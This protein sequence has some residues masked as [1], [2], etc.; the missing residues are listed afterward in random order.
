MSALPRA[1]SRSGFTLIELLVVIAI[2][3]VL[4]ALLLPA[5]QA[6]REAARRSQCVNN[7]KQIG[8]GLHNYESANGTF[9]I[10]NETY[11]VGATLDTGCGPIRRHGFFTLILGQ[12]EQQSV[13]NSVNFMFAAGANPPAMIPGVIQSTALLTRISSY[14]CPSD[15]PGSPYT[16]SDVPAIYNPWG[17][18]SYAGSAGGRNSFNYVSDKACNTTSD[19][20]FGGNAAY[21]VADILDGTSNTIFA[22]ESSKFKNDPPADHAFNTWTQ[23]GNYTSRAYPTVGRP[24]VLLFVAPKMN[25]SIA[26]ML[27]PRTS[28]DDM[29][30]AILT[31]TGDPKWLAV[32][33]WGFRSQHPGGANFLFG[34]GSVKFL[35][36][37]INLTTYLSLGTRANGE[38]ISADQY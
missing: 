1:R 21:R 6:A 14:I 20:A 26:P 28:V 25:G 19:G 23:A 17:Q 33:Q 36:E 11:E 22:G 30:N 32:G 34:D 10:G 27:P 15:F 9:P 24:Q 18:A 4:I 12:I 13:Y 8:L 35:K 2:I 16:I 3:A 37:T 7:L 38:V 5:V 31:T 29:R